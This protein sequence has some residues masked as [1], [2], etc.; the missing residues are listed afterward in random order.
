MTQLHDKAI[1]HEEV[2]KRAYELYLQRGGEHGRHE[3][4]WLLAEAQ[5]LNEG[6]QGRRVSESQNSKGVVR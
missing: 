1:S 3:E 4:D 5:L 2:E 6:G